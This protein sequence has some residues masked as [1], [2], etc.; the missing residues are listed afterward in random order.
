MLTQ[1]YYA[2]FTQMI[3]AIHYALYAFITQIIYADFTQIIYAI[4]YAVYNTLQTLEEIGTHPHGHA[5]T[6]ALFEFSVGSFRQEGIVA[7][8][9]VA[10][11]NPGITVELQSPA[12]SLHYLPWGSLG[13]AIWRCQ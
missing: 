7:R 8:L 2:D 12:R 10:A 1:L 9:R 13:A 5:R 11:T 6:S 4:H 3:Y